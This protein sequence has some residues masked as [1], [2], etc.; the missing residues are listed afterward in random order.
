MIKGPSLYYAT[1]KNIFDALNQ[2]KVDNETIQDMFRKRNIVCS[3]ETDREDLALYFSRLTHDLSDHRELSERLGII[4]RKERKTSIDLFGAAIRPDVLQRSVDAITD[5]LRHDGEV[6]HVTMDGAVLSL[7]I[8]YTITDYR[9]SEFS[10]VQHRVGIIE[11]ISDS[12]KLVIRSTKSDFI[13]G[14][15]DSIANTIEKAVGAGLKRSEISLFHHLAHEKRSV[16]FYEL[17]TNLPDYV[18]YDLADVFVYKPR[19]NNA[20]ASTSL[21]NSSVG[22]DEEDSDPHIAQIFLR[23][24]NISKSDL[25][26]QLTEEKEYYI[27]KVGWT[28]TKSTGDGGRYQMEATFADPARC[29]GFSY[30][31]RGVFDLDK[32]GKVLKNKRSPTSVEIDSVARTIEMKARELVA[33]LDS[34]QLT[35]KKP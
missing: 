33:L 35:G 20:G 8:Q 23:G 18:F 10:Q 16:F 3:R 32:D 34:G 15:R 17:I 7:H 12:A 30:M 21:V 22:D 26:A 25:L 27:A 9:R 11:L 2:S 29:L 13:D 6:V 24:R 14:V 1:D 4:P 28:A 19:P 31:L 5:K